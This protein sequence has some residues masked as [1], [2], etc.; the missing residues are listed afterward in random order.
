MN[1]ETNSLLSQPT[2]NYNALDSSETD[3]SPETP[4][5]PLQTNSPQP[6]DNPQRRW[7]RTSVIPALNIVPLKFRL[8]L[9][10]ALLRFFQFVVILIFFFTFLTIFEYVDKP[11]S[12]DYSNLKF[13][14]KFNPKSYLTPV[15]SSFGE[16]NVL[17]DGH[18][19]TRFSDGSMNPEKL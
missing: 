2:Q 17:L 7:L 1:Q 3:I 18:S 14:W 8:Y 19:H 5:L 16:F 9:H 6:S 12:S 15:N 4:L 11:D 10:D 13:D